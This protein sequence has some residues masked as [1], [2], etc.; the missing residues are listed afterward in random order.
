MAKR[1]LSVV[2]G[3]AIG[4]GVI[5]LTEMINSMNIVMPKDLDMNNRDAMRAWMETLPLSAYL[6]VLGGYVLASVIGSLV[7]TLIAGRTG[8]RQGMIVGLLL[9]L[10]NVAN[11]MMLPQPFW[12]AVV[13][14]VI[15]LPFAYIGF[16]L[17]RK[18]T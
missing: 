10:A 16:L 18:K 17:A 2:I 3:L 7:A 15:Y 4:V 8:A 12:F 11:L 13:S 1:I 9:T 14:C 5:F 6:V